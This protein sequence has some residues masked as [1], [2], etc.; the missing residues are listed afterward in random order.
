MSSVVIKNDTNVTINGNSNINVLYIFNFEVY[1]LP[2]EIFKKFINLKHLIVN[3]NH[4]Q[5][6]ED[7]T[8][9]DAA[10][11]EVLRLSNNDLRQLKPF[12]FHA[13]NNLKTLDLGRNKIETIDSKSFIGLSNLERLYLSDNS[14]KLLPSRILFPLK[15]LISL[16]LENNQIARFDSDV[17]KEN[18][19]IRSMG[20]SN[21]TFK[22]IQ[23]EIFSDLSDLTDLSVSELRL[24]SLNLNGTKNIQTLVLRNTDIADITLSN[25]PKILVTFG[26][27]IEL[28]KFVIDET[29]AD[30]RK[31]PNWGGMFYNKNIR[32]LFYFKKQIASPENIESYDGGLYSFFICVSSIAYKDPTLTLT[33]TFI[34]S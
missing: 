7:D 11:L 2:K 14:L 28:M 15:K 3:G 4:V 32:F 30:F 18:K 23:N 5:L 9:D 25:F 19:L 34:S 26:T 17:F 8:F 16:S 13:M 20:L 22:E 1:K 27:N 24:T 33:S 6:L 29:T 31:I 21:N 10:R 12:V